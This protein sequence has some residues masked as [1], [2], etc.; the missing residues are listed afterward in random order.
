[1]TGQRRS[2]KSFAGYGLVTVE[3][4]LCASER[5]VFPQAIDFAFVTD[6]NVEKKGALMPP[7]F[8]NFMSVRLISSSFGEDPVA[9][10]ADFFFPIVC[11]GDSSGRHVLNL[12]QS[13]GQ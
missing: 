5:L 2:K 1:M 8:T 4:I 6:E 9:S 3:V 11:A 10:S 7:Y 12:L 13:F